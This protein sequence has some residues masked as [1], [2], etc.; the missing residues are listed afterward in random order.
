MNELTEVADCK[1]LNSFLVVRIKLIRFWAKS[2]TSGAI[3]IS[4]D[5]KYNHTHIFQSRYCSAA[6]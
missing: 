3:K 2:S 4:K 1:W 5:E 6:L